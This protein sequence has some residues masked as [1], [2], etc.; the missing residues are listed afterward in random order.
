MD[1]LNEEIL[2]IKSLFNNGRLYGNLIEEQYATDTDGDGNIDADEATL[3]LYDQGYKVLKG[4]SSSN[5]T[6]KTDIDT[7]A[8]LKCVKDILESKNIDYDVYKQGEL[9]GCVILVT[10]KGKKL[11]WLKNKPLS[12]ITFSFWEK[13]HYKGEDHT[14]AIDVYFKTEIDH[15]D[16]SKF[17]GPKKVEK[18]RN[19]V[20]RGSYGDDCKVEKMWTSEI[21]GKGGIYKIDF[22]TDVELKGFETIEDILTLV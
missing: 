7:I 21:T 13:G 15:V 17:W 16:P 18:V 6:C 3:F 19:V 20:F 2:R 1:N 5:D 22:K 8:H 14:F 11:G 4:G 9:E 10:V 12:N